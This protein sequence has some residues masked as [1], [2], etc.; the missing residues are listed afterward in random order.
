MP[1]RL[2]Q[3]ARCTGDLC[4]GMQRRVVRAVVS[5]GSKPFPVELDRSGADM[6]VAS[7]IPWD[8]RHEQIT[9]QMFEPGHAQVGDGDEVAHVAESARGALGLLHQAVDGFDVGVAAT[10]EHTANDAFQMRLQGLGQALEGLQATAACPTDPFA[11][12]RAGESL[13]VDQHAAKNVLLVPAPFVF[14][15]SSGPMQ[16]QKENLRARAEDI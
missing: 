2:L 16:V 4:G 14:R 3:K 5:G 7:V 11:Q 13:A 1:K 9:G 15:T 8:R 10:V 6:E 12:R